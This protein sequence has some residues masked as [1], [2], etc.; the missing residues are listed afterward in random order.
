MSDAGALL[1]AVLAGI[2][3]GILFF[4]GLWW[5]IRL[6]LKSGAPAPWFLG[7][8]LLRTLAVVTLFIWIGCGSWQLML[9]CLL[10]FF[11][12]RVTLQLAGVAR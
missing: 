1:L 8:L 12:T 6:G 2:G 4:G 3:C 11:A 9:A 5:T 10:G 7:S